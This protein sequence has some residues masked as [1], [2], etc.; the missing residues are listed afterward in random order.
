[1]NN[2]RL[3]FHTELDLGQKKQAARIYVDER[4]W[5]PVIQADFNCQGYYPSSRDEMSELIE[6]D[7]VVRDA[8]FPYG[9]LV[10]LGKEEEQWCVFG[11]I[12]TLVSNDRLVKGSFNQPDTWN[13][14]TNHR[15]LEPE[16]YDP[17]GNRWV[18]FAIQTDQSLN[19]EKWNIKPADIIVKGVRLLAYAIQKEYDSL[20]K[21]VEISPEVQ[22]SM[23]KYPITSINPLT[24]LSGFAAFKTKYPAITA[25]DYARNLEQLVLKNK[26]PQNQ[27][28]QDFQEI[29]KRCSLRY[30][31]SRG[32]RLEQVIEQFR[33]HD[34][35]SQG[36]GAS[37]LYSR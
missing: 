15:Q 6:A 27:F 31:L 36:Y 37:V 19:R 28:D 11:S 18:C 12:H 26:P 13:V 20:Q 7:A 1:M 30:H 17:Q 16:K 3:A 24:R 22:K 34:A 33:I 4:N 23:G 25:A 9:H 5:G 35:T 14:F 2:L 29:T 21:E 32:A 8:I 10:L